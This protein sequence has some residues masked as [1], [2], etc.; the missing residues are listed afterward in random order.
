MGCINDPEFSDVTFIVQGHKFYAHKVILS[1]ISD[2]FRSMFKSGMAESKMQEIVLD[3]VSY[4]V[5][6]SIMHFLYTGD[7]HFGADMEG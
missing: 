6:S 2:H 1:L 7:F 3:D 4:P 5:F